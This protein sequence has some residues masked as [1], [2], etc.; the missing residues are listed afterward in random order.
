[1][2][3][4]QHE[5]NMKFMDILLRGVE[6][7]HRDALAMARDYFQFIART[8]DPAVPAGAAAELS[9]AF[10]EEAGNPEA[11]LMEMSLRSAQELAKA[12][13]VVQASLERE[14]KRA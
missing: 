3:R 12:L 7:K 8:P 2:S 4:E 1:M 6:A 11:Y 5:F 9:E 14:A 13:R 10:G